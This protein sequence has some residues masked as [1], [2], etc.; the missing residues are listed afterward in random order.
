MARC[1][2]CK[3]LIEKLGRKT[4]KDWMPFAWGPS[5]EEPEHFYV[6]SEDTPEPPG[7]NIPQVVD[8]IKLCKVPSPERR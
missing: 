6:L 4:P 8:T 5:T 7:P 2:E 1:W 3:N